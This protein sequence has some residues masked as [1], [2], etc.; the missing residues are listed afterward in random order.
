MSDNT[1]TSMSNIDI[2]MIQ[3]DSNTVIEGL[4]QNI[5][6]T[7]TKNKNEENYYLKKY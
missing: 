6:W 4:W 3:R 5:F 1:L 7:P 2:N